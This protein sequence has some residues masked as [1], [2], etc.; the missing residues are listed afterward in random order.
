MLLFQDR[1]IYQFK[2]Q[3]N[4][5]Q[6]GDYKTQEEVSENG[7]VHGTY[8]VRESNGDLRVVSYTAG[9]EKGFQVCTVSFS[10]HAL[11]FSVRLEINGFLQ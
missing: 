2:Y 3:V 1:P 7:L 10:G 8:T 4:D 9:D 5:A 6:T 11:S